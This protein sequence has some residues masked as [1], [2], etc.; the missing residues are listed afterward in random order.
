MSII[1][2]ELT[3]AL[4][5]HISSQRETIRTQLTELVAFPSVHGTEETKQAC[6]DAAQAVTKMYAEL[7]IEL[8]AHHTVDGSIALSG[9]VPASS[10][11]AKTVLLYS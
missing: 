10:E 7:G 5:D 1:N 6:I 8:K 2:K 3:D 4:R 9:F 11:S